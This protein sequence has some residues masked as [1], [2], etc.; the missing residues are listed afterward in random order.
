ARSENDARGGDSADPGVHLEGGDEGE[1]FTHETACARQPH[2]RH[3]EDEEGH[4]VKRH[5]V[6]K[7][8]ISRDLARMDAV[9]DDADAKKECAG[10]PAMAEHLEDA[11]LQTLRVRREDTH[12]HEAHMGD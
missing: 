4:S 3:C 6:H 2:I 11:A 1:E 5:P 12:R 9:I 7:T 10:N 8:A